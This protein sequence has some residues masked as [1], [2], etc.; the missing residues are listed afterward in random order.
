MCG[1][2]D[3]RPSPTSPHLGHLGLREQL[4]VERDL[5]AEARGDGERGTELRERQP[6][7]VPR[8]HRL[9]QVELLRVRVQD[10]EAAVA[11]RG[12]RSSRAAELRGQARGGK[13]LPRV[14]D[15]DEPAGGLQSE[16]RRHGLLEQRARRRHGCA[17]LVREL[18]ARARNAVELGVDERRRVSCDERRRRVEDVLA[19]RAVV[20]VL[21]S[22]AQR[23]HEWLDGIAGVSSG[24][25]KVVCIETFGRKDFVA[26]LGDH[27]DAGFGARERT[28]RLEHRAEP[29]LVRDG[30]TNRR[31]HEE[32]LEAAQCAKKTV[33][34]SPCSRISKR[35]T[36]PTTSATSVAR[37]A[38]SSDSRTAS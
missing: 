16:R 28:L 1:I 14:D 30:L 15:P 19:R 34:R 24:A 8:Q 21:R 17:M 31:R 6:A 4:E 20:H 33:C 26:E 38:G 13:A 2:V 9:R 36:P 37:S 18:R 35:R 23:A 12:E 10:V 3:E 22:L 11:E 32:R 5:C 25:R 27:A 7:R 29:G